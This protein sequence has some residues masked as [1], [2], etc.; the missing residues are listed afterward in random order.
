[1]FPFMSIASIFINCTKKGNKK[2]YTRIRLFG[3]W[4]QILEEQKEENS[5]FRGKGNDFARN[6]CCCLKL[7]RIIKI[8]S[9]KITLTLNLVKLRSQNT[10]NITYYLI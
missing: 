7:N 10:H 6:I 9:E 8:N 2:H 5:M 1:M 3:Q 4:Y